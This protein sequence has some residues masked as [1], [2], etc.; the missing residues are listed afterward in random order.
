MLYSSGKWGISEVP[1]QHAVKNDNAQ[2][3]QLA[4]SLESKSVVHIDFGHFPSFAS[5]HVKV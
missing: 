5:T 1:E 3:D 2:L 4:T